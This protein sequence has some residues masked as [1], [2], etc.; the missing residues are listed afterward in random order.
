MR[1]EV[2]DGILFVYDGVN[3]QP[4]LKQP[5]WPNGDEWRA[6]EAEAWAGTLIEALTNPDAD[7]AGPSRDKPTEPRP[8]PELPKP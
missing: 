8:K 3:P 7:L 2:K 1:Y 6:G 4:F 5:T